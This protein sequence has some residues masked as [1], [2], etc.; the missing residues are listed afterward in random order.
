MTNDKIKI[1]D[2][3]LRD[4]EQ[5]PGC[6]M[7]LEEKLK[8]FEALE[9]LNVDIVEAGFAIA[10]EGDFEAVKEVAKL[11]KKTTVCSLAR[12]N[13]NDIERAREALSFAKQFRIHT[14]I[15][16][17]DLHMKYKLQMTKEEVLEKIKESVSYA[18]KFT[19]D[20]EWSAE[21]GSRSDFEYLCKCIDVAIKAGA[22][23][24]N[25]PDTVG[26]CMPK[27]YQN[28]FTNIK[29]NV[30]NIDKVTL[31]VHC[32]NDLGL[33]VANSIA[34][35]DGGA[36]QVECTVNGIGERA[37]NASM[38][39]LVMMIKTRKDMLP[40]YTDINTKH[41]INASRVLS[42]VTSFSVQPN[43]AIVGA[44]AFAHE[45]GIHQDGML[46]HNRTYEIMNPESIG[47]SKSKLVLGKHSGRHAFKEKLNEMGYSL[48]D[49]YINEAFKKFKQLCDKKKE[50]FDKDIIALVDTEV[51]QQDEIIKLKL[52]EV[53]CGSTRNPKVKVVLEYKGQEVEKIDS[54]NGPVDSIFKSINTLIK[55]NAKLE[56]FLI[57]AITKGTDAQAEVSVRLKENDISV[58]GMASDT[59]TMVAAAR[60]YIIALN[61][62]ILKRKK[63]NTKLNLSTKKLMR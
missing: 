56:L 12:A 42:A 57:N 58:S 61:K 33:A 62:L 15:A 35:I 8:V 54:G 31:S 24:I 40:Y 47:L 29:N 16:T 1:F 60:A 7:N 3:T 10:S 23:T 32:H 2:T 39:E 46:K 53:N 25:I 22:T 30:S 37:G 4:G 20:V 9:Y 48:G 41:I 14:F 18:R 6:S 34:G 59:D 43:K 63:R 11:A 17:S 21:D 52:L 13:K 38:E 28:I 45:S 27:E 55:N 49:N 50:I 26:Y 5:S 51:S 19:D 44:N 36:R